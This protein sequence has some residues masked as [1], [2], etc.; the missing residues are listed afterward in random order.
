MK[1]INNYIVEKLKI[2][3]NIDVKYH[4]KNKDELI[5]IVDKLLDERGIN[6]DLNDIDVSKV[7]DFGRLFYQN[8]KIKNIDLSDW[9]VSNAEYMDE[10]FSGCYHFNSDISSWDVSKV[11]NFSSMFSQCLHLSNCDFELW[12]N[13]ISKDANTYFMF[14]GCNELKIPSWYRR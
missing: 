4:P 8:T 7:K 12:K 9:D 10:M 1:T 11:K 14:S 2:N 3:K 6:A 13:K 5:E